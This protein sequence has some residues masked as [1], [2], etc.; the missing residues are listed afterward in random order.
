MHIVPH[1]PCPFNGTSQ[2]FRRIRCFGEMAEFYVN[3]LCIP[4]IDKTCLLL[5][6]VT[7]LIH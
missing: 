7:A 1:I 3:F 5:Y 4:L 2:F 6:N